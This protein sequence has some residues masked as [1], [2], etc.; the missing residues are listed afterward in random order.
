MLK[1]VRPSDW[2]WH[3]LGLCGAE[4]IK[5]VLEQ[6]VGGF[7]L[8]PHFVNSGF[9]GK[10]AV[11]MYRNVLDHIRRRHVDRMIVRTGG[12]E[13][14]FGRC[15]GRGGGVRWGSEMA[16]GVHKCSEDQFSEGILFYCKG[17]CNPVS[18]GTG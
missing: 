6:L 15:V 12:G 9:D 2:F 1:A 3:I 10:D 18:R 17:N 14:I 4:S 11:D 16:Y 5:N 13:G 7:I 8:T